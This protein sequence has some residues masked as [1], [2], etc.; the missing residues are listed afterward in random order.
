M[1][2]T[3]LASVLTGTDGVYRFRSVGTGAY[4]VLVTPPSSGDYTSTY[5]ICSLSPS[6]APARN[7]YLTKTL[8]KLAPPSYTTVAGPNVVLTWAGYPEADS[9]GVSIFES[10][11]S[12]M[13][14]KTGTPTYTFAAG[15]VGHTYNWIAYA[16][17]QQCGGC[18]IA[19]STI[20]AFTVGRPSYP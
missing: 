5:S 20:G 19:S 4:N 1:G 10:G 16:Y 2:D 9:Y 11:A 14:Q 17:S 8:Q 7:V 13:Y 15:A 6:N 12:S 18:T 3:K